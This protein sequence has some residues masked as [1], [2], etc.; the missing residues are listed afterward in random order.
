VALD[1]TF[2]VRGQWIVFG[3]QIR[4]YRR[5]MNRRLVSLIAVAG[6]AAAASTAHGFSVGSATDPAGDAASADPGLDISGAGFY[7]DRHTGRMRGAV[8]LRGAPADA[9]NVLVTIYGGTRT[10]TGECASAPGAAFIASPHDVLG[11]WQRMDVPGDAAAWGRSLRVGS[12][13]AVQEFEE[14]DVRLRGMRLDCAAAG[15]IDAENSSLVYDEIGPFNLTQNPSIEAKLGPMPAAMV[16]GRARPIRVTIT[17]TGSAS[18]KPIRLVVAPQRGLRVRG[19]L[20]Q[21]PIAPGG[22]RI[23]TL[24]VTLAANARAQTTLRVTAVSGSLRARVE[25]RLSLRRPVRPSPGGRTGGGRTKLCV[26][27]QPDLSGQTGGSL[28]TVICPA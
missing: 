6:L 12:N 14:S 2:A 13:P 27:W 20:G 7:Y 26:Q 4:W 19:P 22:R 8:A 3:P 23:V 5:A 24:Q 28:V 11:R 25:N 9:A 17:N 18:T 16:P 1:P 10:A 15:V 21:R